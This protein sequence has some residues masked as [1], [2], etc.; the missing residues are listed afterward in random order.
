[1][2]AERTPSSGAPHPAAVV[3]K[4]GSSVLRGPGDLPAAAAEIVR[5]RRSGQGVVAVVSA[6]AGDT[7]RLIAEAEAAGGARSR[8]APRLVALGEEKSAALLAMV[9][10]TLGLDVA[11]LDARALGLRAA[12]P[13][14]DATPSAIDAP[15]L[16]AALLRRGAVIV[17]GFV[18][19]GEAGDPVLLGRGGSDL[20]AVFLAAALGLSE[21]VLL[22]D[23]DG[24]YDRDPAA[25]D[26]ARR[27]DRVDP[28]VARR[29]AGRLLQ[30]K[31]IDFAAA[32]DV[33]IRVRAIG[34]DDGTLVA[35]LKI[36]GDVQI[37]LPAENDQSRLAEK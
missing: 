20:T 35:P 37:D 2:R 29:V 26:G 31:A 27:Y 3:L 15:R 5:R 24:V 28:G 13:A 19:I 33:A 9:C 4:F 8:H 16:A 1:M 32:H 22:K 11:V 18:A 12:G 21:A 7:D 17:P 36:F 25:A 30:P 34:G 6:F 10:E 14:T 23:V